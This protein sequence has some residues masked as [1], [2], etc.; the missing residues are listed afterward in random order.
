M[1][2]QHSIK[3][4]VILSLGAIGFFFAFFQ[5]VAP[6]AMIGDL[7]R[8]FRCNAATIGTLSAFYF[9]AYICLQVPVGVM[10][11]R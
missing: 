11:D 10:A 1:S 4:W 6:S 3:P 7:M 2:G 5:R 9:Y 8:D